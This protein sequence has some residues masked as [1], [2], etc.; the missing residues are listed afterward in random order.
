MNE[1]EE[2]TVVIP[3]FR[4]DYCFLIYFIWLTNLLLANPSYGE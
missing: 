4:D 2:E 1:I 3:N